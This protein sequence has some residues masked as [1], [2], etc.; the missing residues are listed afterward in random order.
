MLLVS[1]QLSTRIML[2][3]TASVCEPPRAAVVERWLAASPSMA[4]AKGKKR[5]RGGRRRRYKERYLGDA[6]PA[7]TQSMLACYTDP[8]QHCRNTAH[9][10][11]MDLH[12]AALLGPVSAA[13]LYLAA[14]VC[15]RG[16]VVQ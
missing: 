14:C 2:T 1:G 10:G 12:M 6:G 8:G 5:P 16:C 7:P 3:Y 13:G 9:G 11:N 15:V 4:K